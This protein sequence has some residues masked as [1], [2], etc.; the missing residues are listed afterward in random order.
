MLCAIRYI[1]SWSFDRVVPT[2]L[3]EVSRFRT[4]W[5]TAIIAFVA[6]EL[7]LLLYVFTGVIGAMVNVSLLIVPVAIGAGLC[8]VILPYRKKAWF[9]SASPFIQKKLGS[10]PIITIVGLITAVGSVIFTVAV[11]I[12]PQVTGFPVTALN[13]EFMVGYFML[14]V[15]I[16]YLARFFR[17]KEGIDILLNFA[18]IPPE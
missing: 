17:K 13:L 10:V 4:P 11:V 7:M 3:S 18:A 14:G 15:V 6:T 1:F 2:K 8:A 9:E 16:F 12:F 5:I